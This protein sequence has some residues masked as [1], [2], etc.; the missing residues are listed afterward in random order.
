MYLDFQVMLIWKS[1]DMIYLLD[2]WSVWNVRGLNS[3]VRQD[4][5]KELVDSSQ[6]D[7]VCFQETKMQFISRGTILSMLGSQFT[8]FVFLPSAGASGGLETSAGVHMFE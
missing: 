1:Y 3:T 8:D 4:S 7:V 5:V 6:V 2:E